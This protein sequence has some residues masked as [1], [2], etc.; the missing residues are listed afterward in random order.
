MSLQIKL[1]VVFFSERKVGVGV[2]EMTNTESIKTEQIQKSMYSTI[3]FIRNSRK[4]NTL[5]QKAY[6]LMPGASGGLRESNT[7]GHKGNL[8]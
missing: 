4:G 7:R 5:C 8:G 1:N 6:Q 3:L 2:G